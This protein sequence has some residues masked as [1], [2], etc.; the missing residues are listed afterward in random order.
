MIG[1]L[2]ILKYEDNLC[3]RAMDKPLLVDELVE[4]Q[5][6]NEELKKAIQ[7][8]PKI[9]RDRL[10]KYYFEDMTLEEIAREEK[11]SKVAIKYSIDIAIEKI[12]KKFKN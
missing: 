6:I 10:K 9:Q 4:N 11:C 3:T 5:I 7:A 2:N 1:I 8:L 12:S